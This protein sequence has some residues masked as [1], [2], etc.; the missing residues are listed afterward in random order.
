LPQASRR[1][2]QGRTGGVRVGKH[3][4]FS[5]EALCRCHRPR[6]SRRHVAP[7]EHFPIRRDYATLSASA[8][9]RRGNGERQ[10]H[11]TLR[12]RQL[13]RGNIGTLVN[14][15]SAGLRL[16]EHRRDL[17]GQ[18]G[19]M[20]EAAGDAPAAPLDRAQQ[21]VERGVALQR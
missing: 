8:R 17:L 4:G 6:R 14:R 3:L 1:P 21:R 18:V 2:Y 10:A 9:R 19:Q 15:E 7:S 11:R 20:N 5:A 16:D 13:H 12:H